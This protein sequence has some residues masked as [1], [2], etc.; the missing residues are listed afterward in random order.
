MY[1]NLPPV[2]TLQ[3]IVDVCEQNTQGWASGERCMVIHQDGITYLLFS[4]IFYDTQ[5]MGIRIGTGMS[6]SWGE[7]ALYEWSVASKEQMPEC[8]TD[9]LAE[10]GITALVIGSDQ[11]TRIVI[12]SSTHLNLEGAVAEAIDDT[13]KKD[14]EADLCVKL[15][16]AFGRN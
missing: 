3:A 1:D 9:L 5:G 12:D 10:K 16:P 14:E 2:I 8:T 11:S 15:S 7:G 13:D 4:P 6:P